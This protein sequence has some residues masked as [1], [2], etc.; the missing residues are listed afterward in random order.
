VKEQTTALPVIIANLDDI[1]TGIAHITAVDDVMR[2]AHAGLGLPPLR[3]S[4]PGLMAL[5]RIIIGQQVSIASARAI[6]TRF[7]MVFPE[8]DAARLRQADEADFRKAGLSAPKI[9][10]MRA[11]SEALLEKTIDLDALALMPSGTAHAA[12]CR[13]KGIGPWTADIYLMVCLGHADAFPA[14]DLALQEAMRMIDGQVMRPDTKAMLARVQA[15]RPWR[16]VGARMLWQIYALRKQK[17][18]F[19]G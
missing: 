2:K 10:T 5:V 1:A 12:L 4:A 6:E 13:I 14:G 19:G 18:G 11:I 7:G 16:A 9:R 15:W 3:R 17:D 8:V